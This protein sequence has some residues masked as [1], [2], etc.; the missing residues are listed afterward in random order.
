MRLEQTLRSLVILP[1]Y[2]ERENLS[3]IVRAVLV[4]DERLDVLFVDDNSPDGTGELAEEMA[5]ASTRVHVLHRA[6]KL[7]LGTAYLAGF[8]YALAQRYLCV[9]EMDADLSH[10]PADLPRLLEPVY[11]HQAD[12]VLGSRWVKG[13]GTR[14]WPLKR[15][16]LSRGGSWYA[17]S[18]LGLS[19][20]DLTGG[21]KC[22]HRSVLDAIDLDTIQTTGYGFQIELTYRAL[23]AGFRVQEVPI[24]FTE[25]LHGKSK[26][27]SSIVTEAVVLVWQLRLARVLGKLSALPGAWSRNAPLTSRGR[28]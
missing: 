5:T 19:I 26:M 13:G 16:L 14:N 18:V 11:A 27:S 6:G 20:R 4:A 12:L 1:T 24:V 17:R 25:R 22:F 8:Q 9:L 10:N 21:F 7:G 3:Q 2:N 23:H 28:E 15:R